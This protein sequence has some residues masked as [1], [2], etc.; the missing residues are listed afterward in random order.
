MFA[1]AVDLDLGKLIGLP[2][3]S[4]HFQDS[5]FLFRSNEPNIVPELGGILAGY[6]GTPV[7]QAS[8]LSYLTYEQKLLGEKL[9]IEVG[10][11]NIHRYFLIPNGLDPFTFDSLTFYA[12]RDVNGFPYGLW[13]GRVNHHVTPNW[14]VQAGAFEDD[15]PRA[16]TNDYNLGLHGVSGVQVLGKIAYRCSATIWVKAGDNQ[17]ACFDRAASRMIVAVDRCCNA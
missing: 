8:A 16:V 17:G 1:P 15:Y 6:Q 7:R 10:R 11:T 2:G 14:Y 12:G 3:G 5:V 9:S 13:G 4:I